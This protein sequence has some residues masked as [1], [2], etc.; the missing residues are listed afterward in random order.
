METEYYIGKDI[1]KLE[2]SM[3]NAGEHLT[4]LKRELQ[5]IKNEIRELKQILKKGESDGE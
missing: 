5:Q 3:Q 4:F 2:A 1:G